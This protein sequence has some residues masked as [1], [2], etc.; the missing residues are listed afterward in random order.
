[1]EAFPAAAEVAD[2]SAGPDGAAAPSAQPGYG[3]TPVPGPAFRPLNM[4]GPDRRRLP[5]A[6]EHD[7]SSS[8]G[9]LFCT[10]APST[11][12]PCVPPWPFPCL[13]CTAP[14]T[15]YRSIS[16]SLNLPT[17]ERCMLLRALGVLC[18]V[19]QILTATFS[20]LK[21]YMLHLTCKVL[22]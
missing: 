10:K 8:L 13:C 18:Q 21:L 12:L 5:W 19:N 20:C 2:R 15:T 4:A 11:R 22:L 9:L 1:M 14:S 7:T 6:G 17:S 3:S 16:L